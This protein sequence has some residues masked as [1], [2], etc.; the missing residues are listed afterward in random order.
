[1]SYYYKKK[2]MTTVENKVSLDGMH[3]SIVCSLSMACMD[4]S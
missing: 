1:M 4:G 3:G 2:R